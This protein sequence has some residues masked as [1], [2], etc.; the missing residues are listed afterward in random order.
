MVDKK[1][2]KRFPIINT[3]VSRVGVTNFINVIKSLHPGESINHFPITKDTLQEYKEALKS[4]IQYV[5]K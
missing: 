2:G 5:N 4:W 3:R 1:R